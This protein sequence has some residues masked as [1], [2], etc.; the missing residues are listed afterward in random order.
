MVNSLF[1][2]F[3][4]DFYYHYFC[5]VQS[6]F[7][8]FFWKKEELNKIVHNRVFECF[9]IVFKSI[10]IKILMTELLIYNDNYCRQMNKINKDI[11]T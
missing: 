8:L 7:Y 9:V 2:R 5:R 4:L 1:S 6:L 3:K 10:K 11:E